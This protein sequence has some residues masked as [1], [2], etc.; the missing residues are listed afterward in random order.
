VAPTAP[1]LADTLPAAAGGA[2]LIVAT[3]AGLAAL[4]PDGE[5][6]RQLTAG[7][8]DQAAMDPVRDLVWLAAGGSLGVVDL[9]A[10]QPVLVPIA[11]GLPKDAP[12]RVKRG[13][14]RKERAYV[15]SSSD[16]REDDWVELAWGPHSSLR[17][18]TLGLWED[19]GP[20]PDLQLVGAAWLK[21]QW[22]RPPRPSAAAHVSFDAKSRAPRP[23][24]LSVCEEESLCGTSAPFGARGWRLLVTTHECG[25][26]C[27]TG[28]LLWDPAAKRWAVPDERLDWVENPATTGSCGRYAF[29]AAGTRWAIGARVCR[30][31]G[32]CR[33]LNGRALGWLPPGPTVG[34]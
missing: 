25:D 6:V 31:D 12:F 33:E 15:L 20:K 11:R 24:D 34:E 29:D 14:L 3:P 2:V 1:A 23:K 17:L 21:D 28:C 26:F 22:Q 32:P 27:Y 30:A 7:P 13:K 9:R 4:S 19:E 18:G 5:V 10:E 16:G 8:I